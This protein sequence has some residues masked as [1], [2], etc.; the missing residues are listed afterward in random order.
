MINEDKLIM[1]MRYIVIGYEKKR[2]HFEQKS[3]FCYA[4]KIVV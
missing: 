4:P 2:Y 3:Y 1:R